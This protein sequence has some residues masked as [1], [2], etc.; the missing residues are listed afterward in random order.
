MKKMDSQQDKKRRFYIN[1]WK[2]REAYL[3]EI[4]EAIVT[5]ADTT[6]RK[7]PMTI[8]LLLEQVQ[9]FSVYREEAFAKLAD[10]EIT[11]NEEAIRAAVE[12][13]GGAK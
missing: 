1:E 10:F 7:F 5:L 3:A 2:D 9:S 4:K 11:T 13:K 12:L 6:G 8:S